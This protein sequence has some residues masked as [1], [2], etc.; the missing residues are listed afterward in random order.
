MDIRSLRF[1]YERFAAEEERLGIG[2]M[3]GHCE[4]DTKKAAPI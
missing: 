3:N 1:D 4:S 2:G